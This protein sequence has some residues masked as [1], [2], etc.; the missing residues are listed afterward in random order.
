MP[1]VTTGAFQLYVVL[2]GTVIDPPVVSVLAN[3]VPLQ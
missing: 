3:G 1:P 2:A